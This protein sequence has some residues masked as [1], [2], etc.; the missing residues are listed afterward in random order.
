MMRKLFNIP[1]FLLLVISGRSQEEITPFQEDKLYGLQDATGKVVVPAK[2]KRIE[3]LGRDLFAFKET[4]EYGMMDAKG[5]ILIEPR[6]NMI[7]GF[8]EYGIA[9]VEEDAPSDK[10]IYVVQYLYG[11]IDTKG[12]EV[13]EPQFQKIKKF[14][15]NNVAVYQH[16]DKYGL[17]NGSG[18]IISAAR[19]DDVGFKFNDLGLL[20][21]TIEGKEGYVNSKGEVIIP[22]EYDNIDNFSQYGME[23]KW[24]ALAVATKNGKSGFID[25]NGKVAIPLEYDA[26]MA[27]SNGLA[28]VR[29]DELWGFINTDNQMVIHP[30]FDEVGWFSGCDQEPLTYFALNK[31]YGYMDMD[32]KVVI[33]AVYDDADGFSEGLAAVKIKKKWG[34]ID[35]EGKEV[36]PFI[37]KGTAQ[38]RDGHAYVWLKGK[39]FY[40]DKNGNQE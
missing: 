10:V 17:L 39:S 35:K 16:Q 33:D 12:H 15:H 22:V 8:N 2:Y 27:F 38:F 31:K 26:V 36:I 24:E 5:I 11:A 34:F 21:V 4:T 6:Y 40:I 23:G 3:P 32:G 37:Y 20:H 9:V 30:Q 13:F 1:L 28:G 19:W 25:L 14:D 18:S 7:Y 29:K